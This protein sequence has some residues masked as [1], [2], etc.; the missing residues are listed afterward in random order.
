MTNNDESYMSMSDL[1]ERQRANR[2]KRQKEAAAAGLDDS[3]LYNLNMS[4]SFIANTPKRNN[5]ILLPSKSAILKRL[6]SH[7]GPSNVSFL[8]GQMDGGSISN[9]GFNRSNSFIPSRTLNK[10]LG[11]PNR[12]ML[13]REDSFAQDLDQHFGTDNCN[14]NILD[15]TLLSIGEPDLKVE[16][17]PFKR[18]RTG[19]LKPPNKPHQPSHQLYRSVSLNPFNMLHKIP[20]GKDR[21]YLETV[22]VIPPLGNLESDSKMITTLRRELSA[23]KAIDQPL[24][25]LCLEFSESEPESLPSLCMDSDDDFHASPVAERKQPSPTKKSKSKKVL[26]L[27][28]LPYLTF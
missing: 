21:D 18:A 22:H 15:D 10:S 14:F 19:G 4:S 1:R 13:H 16:Q 6:Q 23:L 2:A 11:A 25:D 5:S 3:V 7:N 28:F 24:S 20:H 27:A 8:A 26:N 17:N 9:I 12:S